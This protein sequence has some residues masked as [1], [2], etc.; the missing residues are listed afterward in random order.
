MDNGKYTNYMPIWIFM[1]LL[2]FLCVALARLI[3]SIATSIATVRSPRVFTNNTTISENSKN[4]LDDWIVVRESDLPDYSEHN[5]V[6][7]FDNSV[8]PEPEP[9]EEAPL[10]KEE[11]WQSI[12][13]AAMQRAMEGDRG[14]R[15]W[16]TKH[17]FSDNPDNTAQESPL[18]KDVTEALKAMG[19]K[20]SDVE[21][22]INSL[23]QSK[24]YSSVDEL[25]QDVVKSL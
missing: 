15:D 13:D 22:A 2:P 3:E 12:V 8:E 24:D 11:Q 17:V 19:Y 23:T 16:V 10:N 1:F 6:V 7:T 4:D 14:A 25:L 21:K 20:V 9:K 5:T 18:A